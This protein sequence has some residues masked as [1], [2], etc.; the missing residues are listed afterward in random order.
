M[1]NYIFKLFLRSNIKQVHSSYVA[2]IW[3]MEKF[4]GEI[5]EARYL[6]KDDKDHRS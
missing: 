5:G 6:G 2:K 3:V 1:Q 4:D